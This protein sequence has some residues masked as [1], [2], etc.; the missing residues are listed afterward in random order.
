MGKLEASLS[1]RLLWIPAVD[2]SDDGHPLNQETPLDLSKAEEDW[3]S[4]DTQIEA[5][6]R[7]R[8]DIRDFRFLDQLETV[9]ATI[10]SDDM[11]ILYS[12]YLAAERETLFERLAHVRNS[13][14]QA[15]NDGVIEYE[16]PR[17]NELAHALDDIVVD[18]ILNFRVV[19]DKLDEIQISVCDER[20]KRREE[21]IKDWND[22]TRE[23]VGDAN[24]E[25]DFLGSLT[26]TFELSS[27]DK[28]LDI[29]VMEDCVS[30]MRNYRSGDRIDV[31]LAHFESRRTTLEEF[32]RFYKLGDRQPDFGGG[33]RNLVRRARSEA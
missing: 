3:F 10:R 13:I 19:H 30:R 15:A 18:E 17:W 28:S 8:V 14:D 11:D 1:K 24:L 26:K 20:M 5:L 9:W 7:A 27:H 23:P 29:R 12:T 33:L 25:T 31:V 16:G 6:V 32:L 22:L 21:L 4:G 2:L